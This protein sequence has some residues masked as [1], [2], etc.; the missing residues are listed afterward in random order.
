VRQLPTVPLADALIPQS[1]LPLPECST[2]LVEL[3][4]TPSQLSAAC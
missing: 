3:G 1:N 2:P 4:S